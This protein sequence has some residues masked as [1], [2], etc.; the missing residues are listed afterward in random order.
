MIRKQ[1]KWEIFTIKEI[2]KLFN[3][4]ICV[5]ILNNESGL[6]KPIFVGRHNSYE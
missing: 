5:L 3:I 2:L 4:N 1:I 6:F